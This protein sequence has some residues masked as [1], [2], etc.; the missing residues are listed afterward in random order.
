M[1]SC[2]EDRRGHQRAANFDMSCYVG[3]PAAQDTVESTNLFWLLVKRESFLDIRDELRIRREVLEL[4]P[5]QHPCIDPAARHV[6]R[7]DVPVR[8]EVFAE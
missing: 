8:R 2:L 3:P 1:G 5:H 7:R 6:Y 4:R